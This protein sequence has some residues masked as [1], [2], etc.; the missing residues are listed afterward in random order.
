MIHSL[1]AIKSQNKSTMIKHWYIFILLVFVSCIT[2]SRLGMSYK[3]QRVVS[4]SSKTIDNPNIDL[5]VNS[6]TKEDVE[7][8]VKG[9]KNRFIPYVYKNEM[10]SKLIQQYPD[11][12]IDFGITPSEQIK[13]TYIIDAV[14]LATGGVYT[15]GIAPWWG[16]V[17]LSA[18][19][20]ITIPN[21]PSY[22]F[23]F[24]TNESFQI[25]F[26]TYYVAGRKL[27]EKYSIAYN[28]LFDQVSKYSFNELA[29]KANIMQSTTINARTYAFQHKSDIDNGIPDLGFS[30]QFRF[31]LIIGNE[32]YS[33]LQSDLTSE[34]NVHFA[35]NDA[36]A[37]KEYAV[38]VL[39]VP[40]TN[41][42][43]ILDATAAKMKQAIDRISLLSKNSFGNAEIFFYYAGHGLPDEISKEA[44]LIPVDVSG[45]N[46]T[47]GIKL[48]DVYKKLVEY[49]SKMVTVFLD[50]CFSG[51]ARTQGLIASR[52]VK[53]KPKEE[54]LKGNL[55][56]FSASSGEQSSLA[57]NEQEHGLFTYYLLQKV[58]ESKGN[59]TYK[60]LSDYLNQQVGFKSVLINNKEQNPQTNVSPDIQK[61]WQ[62]WKLK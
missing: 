41:I 34:I 49:P 2:P 15:A 45:N 28:N 61:Q 18:E 16:S 57:Y 3:G 4:S 22:N 23:K 56:V 14:F 6:L 32:D 31:A 44:Y 13:K 17:N 38:K 48:T 9:L 7:Y 21:N 37:F 24:Q 52:G 43:L 46:V 36:S 25:I 39:G 54:L 11:L 53:V 5:S 35:R 62:T 58:K 40:E 30:N 59:T 10:L 51:G 19:M 42:T 12:K 60:E 47:D 50:A 33:S 20:S 8:D 55:V 27:T 26:F 1:L 29:D